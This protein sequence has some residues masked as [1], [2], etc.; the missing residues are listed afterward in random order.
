MNRFITVLLPVLWFSY[1]FF[2]DHQYGWIIRFLIGLNIAYVFAYLRK[3]NELRNEFLC[4]MTERSTWVSVKDRLPKKNELVLVN[5]DDGI[6][7]AYCDGDL[8][9]P[10]W[11]CSPIGSYA[12]DGCVFG[13][14]HWMP[15]PKPPKE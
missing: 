11:Q 10:S 5:G 3:Y 2:H 12:G 7:R 8:E 1:C 15:L 6:F 9:F 13:I 4:D 14:T